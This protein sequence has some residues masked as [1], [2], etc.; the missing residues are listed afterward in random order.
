MKDY[1]DNFARY[2]ACTHA[3]EKGRPTR[4]QKVIEKKKRA[5]IAYL[6]INE[7][8]IQMNSADSIT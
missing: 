4:I 6:Y 5:S 7:L 2:L 1:L 8:Y 3:Q